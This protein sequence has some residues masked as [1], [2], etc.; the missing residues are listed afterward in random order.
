MRRLLMAV[1]LCSLSLL[2]SVASAAAASPWWHMTS[3]SRPGHLQPGVARDE[4]QEIAV[5]AVEVEPGLE[6][7]IFE[8]KVKGVV[9]GFFANEPVA[10]NFGLP[11]A[12]AKNIQTALEGSEAYGAGNVEVLGSEAAVAP[13]NLTVKSVGADNDRTVPPIEIDFSGGIGTGGATVAAEAHPDGQIYVTAANL[14]DAS[15]SGEVTVT[16]T[17]PAGLEAVSVHGLSG[18]GAVETGPGNDG[19]VA[20]TLGSSSVCSFN[21]I[22]PPFHQIEVSV[23]VVVKGAHSGEPTQGSVSGGGPAPASTASQI[24]VSDEPTPFGVSEYALAAEE[25]GGTTDRQ[26]GSHP[27]QLTTTLALNQAISYSKHRGELPVPAELPKDLR[28]NL[29]PGLIGNPTP[30]PQCTIKDFET[31]VNTNTGQD[32]CGAQTALGVARITI[33]EQRFIGLETFV[34]PL[35]NLEPARGE[36]ARF[37]FFAH[38]NPVILDTSVRTGGDYGVTVSVPNI[39]QTVGFMKSEVTFWGVPGDS[40][41]DNARGWGCIFEGLGW[42][43][44]QRPACNPSESRNPPPL[45][46]LPTSCLGPLQSTVEAD[47]WRERGTVLFTQL[48]EAIPALGGCN[49]LPFSSSISV[50]P[51]SQAGSTATGLTVGIHVPQEEALNASGLAPAQ[52][53]DTKVVLPAGVALNPAAADGLQ[54]C[55]DIP[56]PGRPEGQF[57]LHE[58]ANSACPEA[59]KVG[60]VEIKTPLLP[61][62]LVGAAYLAAQ[63]QNP[64]GSLV[65]LYIEV[66]DPISGSLVKLAGEV[67]PD[68]VTGQ[69]VSTFANTPQLPFEDFKLHFFGGSRAPLA[70][71]AL[72]GSYSTTASIAPWSGNEAVDS[73]STFQ[74]TSAPNGGPCSNPLPFSPSLTA[75]STNIQ[76]GAF[77]P[78]TTTMSR[79][80]GQQSLQGIQLH[81][82]PGL[83]GL[84]T[85]VK[86][87]DEAQG[88]AGTCGP[89]SE[90]G[91]TIV[92]VGV[93]GTPF[94]VKG[95]RVYITG[96]Y[97]GAPFGLSIV[98]PAKAGPYDLEN[99]P[100]NHPACDCVVV[101]AK[102]AVDRVTAALT[103]TTDNT[104]PYKIPTIIGGI[105]LQIQHVNVAITRPGFTFNPTNC[106][107]MAITGSVQSTQGASSELSVP[108]QVTNCATLAFKP[109][110]KVSTS[111]KTSRAKGASLSVKLTYPK[112]PFGSQANIK[113]VKVDLPKQLPSNLKTLQKACPHQTFEANPAS[114]PVE[115]RVGTAKATTPLLPVPLT[116]PAYFVSYGGAKFPELVV[117]LSGYGVTLDLHGETFINEHTNVTSSTFHTVPDAPV[118]TFELTLPQGKYSALAAPAPLCGKKL[119]MPTRFTAQNGAVIKRST[120]ISVTGCARHKAKKKRR[121]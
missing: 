11:A 59:S 1:T 64:F 34:A 36:P 106:S 8:L 117:V 86:L 7:A 65:A 116:G 28:F 35:F 80:D 91:E 27:F 42:P 38:G 112:A 41:H 75:G 30:F 98:N 103:I 66:E 100:E 23:G 93:G 54:A 19:P 87:C 88:N 4:V 76:A 102:I 9:L 73:S 3:G 24:T 63:A 31:K 72:C 118:G 71:P 40:R 84:L 92:S 74:I 43:A 107:P 18:V 5:G 111:G 108:F 39:I 29:P 119:A 89:E 55:G 105:P 51:D 26:A 115:S 83:S 90:I 69:L 58:D 104:G 99:T 21:G 22:L 57:G 32:G 95:G 110:F 82:P 60:T 50:A 17:V 70:T 14:G 16:A 37:G 52:V 79:E 61:N 109:G 2:G 113:S 25:E 78:F 68:P 121:R 6:L 13:L 33:S 46:S 12:T 53:K 15:T 56:E 49:R 44:N 47:S 10:K 97:E 120:P 94:S 85:G 20:C 45:L 96:P 81:M 77:T 101:R 114:C 48:G 62:P 67:K